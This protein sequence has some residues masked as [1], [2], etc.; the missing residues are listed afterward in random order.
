LEELPNDKSMN[1]VNVFFGTKMERPSLFI[2]PRPGYVV[3]VCCVLCIL[4]FK[5]TSTQ[6]FIFFKDLDLDFKRGFVKEHGQVT[7]IY[8]T[9]FLQENLARNLGKS[10]NQTPALVSYP[11]TNGFLKPR[12]KRFL[13]TWKCK[14]LDLGSSFQKTFLLPGHS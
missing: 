1:L 9:R 8:T 11:P 12:P 6:G 5:N 14:Y 2:F 7:R 10:C 13:K 4:C 3:N